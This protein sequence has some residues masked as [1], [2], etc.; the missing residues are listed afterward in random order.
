[1]SGDFGPRTAVLAA[2]KAVDAYPSLSIVLIGDLAFSDFS[3]PHARIKIISAATVVAMDENPA[4]ALRHGRESSMAVALNQ[5]A[6]GL[7]DACVSSG[8]TGALV[9]LSCHILGVF[10]S[11]SRPAICKLMPSV[12]GRAYLLDI[13]A[14]S[15]CT[16]LQLQQFAL[17]GA[18]LVPLVSARVG[19]LNIG[20]EAGKGPEFIREAAALLM[21]T[22]GIEYSGFIEAD[23]LLKAVVDVIVCDGFSGNI[24][25]KASEGT[26]RYIAAQVSSSLKTSLW[27]RLQAVL[28][29]PLLR[30]WRQQFNPSRYNG[31]ILLGLRGLVIKSHGGADELAL[32]SAITSAYEQVENQVLDSVKMRLETLNRR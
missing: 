2:K 19:L 24:A 20:T 6:D 16:A 3:S 4:H 15:V 29:W 25:L 31:A 12:K 26:A 30:R 18:A 21:C 13:G 9:A 28:A 27:M 1:M 17:M 8:N 14:N 7:A 22:E 32:F 23:Q 5:V 11:V 10:E